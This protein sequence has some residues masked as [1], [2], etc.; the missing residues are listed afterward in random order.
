M[1]VVSTGDDLQATVADRVRDVR[2]RIARLAERHGRR[3]GEV[4][5][6]AVSKTH[7]AA[8]IRAAVAAGQREF[9]ENQLQEA[10][11]KL[12]SLAD[13]DLLW[14]FIGPVQSNKTRGIATRFH[15]LH[16]LDRERIARRLDEQRPDELPPLDV[17]IQVNVSGEPTKAGVSADGL[18]ALAEAV[19]GL[20]RLRLRGLMTIPAPA[21]D[22]E[23]QRRPFRRLRDLRDELEGR[24]LRLDT[25]SMGMS[26]DLEAAI[27]E[28]ATLV[29]VGTAV[30]G[31][32]RRP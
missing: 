8:A 17:C 13:L 28:G 2:A 29:R 30:F 26:D 19:A 4:R 15:W 21:A 7:P 1:A 25:L 6:L 32:R 23:T 14:H 22:L 18:P 20:T 31:P 24:G 10:L 5:L 27:A 16:S 9:G 11:G 3:P 12:D